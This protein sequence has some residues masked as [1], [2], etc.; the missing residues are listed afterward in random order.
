MRAGFRDMDGGF[1]G[2]GD[3]GGGNAG[4]VYTLKVQ[5]AGHQSPNLFHIAGGEEEAQRL[6]HRVAEGGIIVFETLT[7]SIAVNLEHA[8][9][10]NFLVSYGSVKG[11][12]FRRELPIDDDYPVEILFA[13]VEKPVV[14]AVNPDPNS[15]ACMKG[16]KIPESEFDNELGDG[17]NYL[18]HFMIDLDVYGKSGLDDKF[19]SFPDV[20]GE[21]FYVNVALLQLAVVPLDIEGNHDCIEEKPKKRSTK[22]R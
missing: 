16:K 2:G 8:L 7:H 18:M 14:I 10:L 21:M 3:G 13:G 5:L 15:P 12:G 19:L 6:R 20:D 4:T 1:P 22:K 9:W 11:A 17:W